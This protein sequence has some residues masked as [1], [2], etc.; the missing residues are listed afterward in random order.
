METLK[1]LLFALAVMCF[2]ALPEI[3]AR[4]VKHHRFL[5]GCQIRRNYRVIKPTRYRAWLRTLSLR[6]TKIYRERLDGKTLL[7]EVEPFLALM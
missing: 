6:E 7:K 5:L 3:L 4:I 1:I 2:I